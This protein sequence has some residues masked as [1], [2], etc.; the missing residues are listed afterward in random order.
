MAAAPSDVAAT[1]TLGYPLS[2]ALHLISASSRSTLPRLFLFRL[3]RSLP[4]RATFP[5]SPDH[6][7][8]QVGRNAEPFGDFDAAKP[9][10]SQ[11]KSAVAFLGAS[12]HAR[13]DETRLARA[14]PAQAEFDVV[15][16]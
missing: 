5:G 3:S 11:F 10:F 16:P 9:G 4:R 14:K 13:S 12:S 2:T 6:A 1:N 15:E 8:D 7:V